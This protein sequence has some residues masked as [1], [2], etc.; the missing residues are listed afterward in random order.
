ML[1]QNEKKKAIQR[2]LLGSLQLIQFNHDC[3]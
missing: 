2:K 1:L 3:S